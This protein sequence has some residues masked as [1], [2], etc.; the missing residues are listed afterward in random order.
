MWD[1][2]AYLETSSGPR[3]PPPIKEVG[4]TNSARI[5]ALQVMLDNVTWRLNDSHSTNHDLL[6]TNLPFTKKIIDIDLL[7]KF[8]LP[9]MDIY[10]GS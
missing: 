8:K 2:T 3:R 6:V 10:D 5:D 9:H 4:A 1:I 7:D